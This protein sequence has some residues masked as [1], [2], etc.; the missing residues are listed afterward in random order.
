MEYDLVSLKEAAITLKITVSAVQ[1]LI[2]HGDL[3][4]DSTGVGVTRESLRRLQLEI[5]DLRAGVSGA[6]GLETGEMSDE[7]LD[8]L[9]RSRGRL[10]W[11]PS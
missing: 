8:I 2:G 10:P 3:Q 7:E 1:R 6:Q 9:R 4:A 5:R 11:H